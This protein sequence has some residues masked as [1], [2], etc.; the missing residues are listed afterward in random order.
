VLPVS[1]RA[2]KE[3]ELGGGRRLGKITTS[4]SGSFE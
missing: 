2:I 3:M 4:Q 1:R